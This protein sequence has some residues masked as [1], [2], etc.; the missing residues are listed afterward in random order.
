MNDFSE[1]PSDVV[2][3]GEEGLKTADGI[4]PGAHGKEGRTSEVEK[5]SESPETG[6]IAGRAKS[7][8][9]GRR[10]FLSKLDTQQPGGES[11]RK[12]ICSGVR[13]TSTQTDI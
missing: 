3:G 10:V 11:L 4:G 1:T 6:S 2:D 8:K 12:V 13:Y 9:R 5:R 7:M